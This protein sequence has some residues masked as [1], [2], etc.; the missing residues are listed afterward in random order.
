MGEKKSIRTG[1]K[2]TQMRDIAEKHCKR[3]IINIVKELK[4]TMHTGLKGE[5]I[6]GN[7]NYFKRTK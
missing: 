7:I 2:D 6:L 1:F 3:P 4:K 5:Y